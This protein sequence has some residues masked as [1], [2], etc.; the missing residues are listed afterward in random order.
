[1]YVYNIYEYLNVLYVH[2]VAFY[3]FHYTFLQLPVLY[4]CTEYIHEQ[5]LTELSDFPDIKVPSS[6]YVIRTLKG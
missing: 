6:D 3:Y 2:Y 5:H 1:M 4:H